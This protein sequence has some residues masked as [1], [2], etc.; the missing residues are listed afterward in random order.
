MVEV[1]SL[2]MIKN[3]VTQPRGIQFALKVI[4]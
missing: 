3:T 4:F 2:S 1:K